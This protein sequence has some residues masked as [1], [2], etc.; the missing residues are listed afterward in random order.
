[1][2]RHVVIL[3]VLMVMELLLPIPSRSEEVDLTKGRALY[4]KHCQICHGPEGRGDGY[5]HFY[6]PVADLTVSNIQQK[7]DKELWESIH[8]GIPNTPMGM[9]RFVLSD[10]E[11]TTVL[12]YVRSL[13]R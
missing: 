2:K 9:W 5:P 4:V 7:T 6:P 12:A 11:I 1:M 13:G 10:E 3:L 8:M